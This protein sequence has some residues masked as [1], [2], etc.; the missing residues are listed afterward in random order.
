FQATL[1]GFGA[2]GLRDAV[3]AEDHGGAVRHLVEFFHKHRAAL[4][5]VI[6]DKTVVDDFMPHVD[7]GAEILQRALHDL[8]G[9]VHTGTETTRIGEQNVHA[10]IIA[11]SARTHPHRPG[12][13]RCPGKSSTAR[14][15]WHRRR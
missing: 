13:P 7:R 1:R 3:R 15:R 2:Y 5:E 12:A 14:C 8:D 11:H 4:L 10:G 9:T 6:H